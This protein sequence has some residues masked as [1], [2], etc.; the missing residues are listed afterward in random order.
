MDL[1]GTTLWRG[2]VHFA[3]WLAADPRRPLFLLAAVVP[4]V[5]LVARFVLL[6][7]RRML[8]FWLNR[9]GSRAER[10]ALQLLKKEGF[11]LVD[12]SPRLQ[13][14]LLIDGES[15][16]FT[17]TPDYLVRRDG[18]Q[19]VVEVKRKDKGGTIRNGL[20]RRQVVEYALASRLPCLLV[21][22]NTREITLVEMMSA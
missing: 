15:Q 20:V 14:A 7:K 5:F 4:V 2:W 22:M 13:Y 19:Y 1:I 12:D 3:E 9:R 17:I 8:G 11:K 6:L 18:Q 10:A 16:S 21:D